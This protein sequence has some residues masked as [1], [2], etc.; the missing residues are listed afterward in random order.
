MQAIF[1][2]IQ[3]SMSNVLKRKLV[4]DTNNHQPNL[5]IKANKR[6][7]KNPKKLDTDLN[8]IITTLSTEAPNKIDAIK[9][10][11]DAFENEINQERFILNIETWICHFLNVKS[12][13]ETFP[14]R[15][16]VVNLWNKIK[17]KPNW[18]IWPY[19]T[20]AVL[21]DMKDPNGFRYQAKKDNWDPIDISKPFINIIKHNPFVK[22]HFPTNIES[23]FCVYSTSETINPDTI[24]LELNQNYFNFRKQTLERCSKLLRQSLIKNL[25]WRLVFKTSR[26][27]ST[28]S[29][30]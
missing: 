13:N 6:G 19:H 14:I 11:L 24:S 25:T 30:L 27:Y 28:S 17:T 18:Y 9:N 5:Q 22:E 7:K 20:L 3:A 26:V 23:K 4:V 2:Y 15:C 29:M 1:V 12:S 21:Y 10:D 8:K 16:I